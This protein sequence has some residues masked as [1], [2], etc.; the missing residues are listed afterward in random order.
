MIAAARRLAILAALAVA[1]AADAE[2]LARG[3][4]LFAP[5][6][7]CHARE[8]GRAG[9]AGPSLAGLKGRRIGGDPEFDYSPV[10]KQ[11]NASGATWDEERLIRFL[12]DPEEMFPAMWMSS[13]PMPGEADH[14]ALA[15]YV[16]Q[17]TP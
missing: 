1:P 13:R 2:D 8:P 5:C 4:E 14:R 17:D 11:A 12:A 9:M 15:A 10:L 7:A 6:T 3:R 16:L